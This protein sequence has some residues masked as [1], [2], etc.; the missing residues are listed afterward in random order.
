MLQL[1]NRIFN[2]TKFVDNAI[3]NIFSISGAL[4]IQRGFWMFRIVVPES[5]IH[6]CNFYPI[7]D[8]EFFVDPT[9]IK[10]QINIFK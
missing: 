4:E 9:H 6:I 1:D 8:C 7:Y 5:L 10:N 2:C 3:S